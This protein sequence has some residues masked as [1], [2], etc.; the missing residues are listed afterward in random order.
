MRRIG[1]V[2]LAASLAMGVP[3]FGATPAQAAAPS[4]LTP[5]NGAVITSGSE[6]SATARF[7]LALT[8][9]LWVDGPGIG[10]RILQERVLTGR[11]SGTFPIRRNGDYTVYLKG[12][13]TGRIYDS[14]TIKV[15]I[16]PAVPS[17]VSVRVSGRELLVSWKRGVEDD[18]TGYTLS[19]SG[20][21][22]KSGSVGSFCQGKSCSAKLAV[23]RV[24]G[25]V[26]VGVRA[27]RSSGGGG[28]LYSGSAT[29][30][31]TVSGGSAAL[32][33]GSPSSAGAGGG[34]PGVGIPLN[35]QAPVTVPSVRPDGAAPDVAHP[36]PQVVN[37]VPEA[38]D[39]VATDRLR[40]AKSVGIALVL[41]IVAAHLGMWTRGLRV[42]QAR[43]SSSGT[44]ARVARGGTG[45]ERVRRARRQIARAEALAKTAPAEPAG[46]ADKGAEGLDDSRLPGD[47]AVHIPLSKEAKAAG[48]AGERTGGV[49]VRAAGAT[50][51]T[52][53]ESR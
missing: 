12:K 16:A 27:R 19:G 43:V 17:G 2:A 48:S 31:A 5:A 29:V 3:V 9:Q 42:A 38:R 45:R 10:N 35:N 7:E 32:Q 23:T 47:A 28:A 40:W 20:V 50:S 33:G 46:A 24:S 30:S 21:A 36:A 25:P 15:R 52:G 51:A 8:M 44:A 6:L 1:A 13:E 22:S 18:L 41:L 34:L 49:N 14:N 53:E 26:S 39:V 4:V 37:G 11:L